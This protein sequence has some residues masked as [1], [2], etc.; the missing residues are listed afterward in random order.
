MEKPAEPALTGVRKR[1]QIESTNKQIFTWVAI[2]AVIVSFCVIA[3]QFL[4]KEFLFNQKIINAKSETNQ[5]LEDNLET[6]QKLKDNV[7]ALL[8]NSDLGSVKRNDGDAAKSNLN[9][10][11]DALPVTGDATGFANSLQAVVLPLS[12]VSIKEL[13]TT[14]DQLAADADVPTADEPTELPFT[15]T[16]T[17]SYEN[18]HQ[19]L[20]DL[21][22][23]IRPVNP[24]ELTI[25]ASDDTLQLSISGVTY[26][27]PAETI[28][29][30]TKKVQP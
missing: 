13:S 28:N 19:A 17:G 9:V 14:T 8:A 5:R 21:A 20:G 11:L 16:I 26:Y 27:L 30:A 25:R 22:R 10:V 6:A 15:A 3:L 12:G 1:Q 18:V 4:G 2:A 24:T 29:V 7:N 23:V